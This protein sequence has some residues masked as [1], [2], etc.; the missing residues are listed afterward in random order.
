MRKG[1]KKGGRSG[2][3][4]GRKQHSCTILALGGG[5]GQRGGGAILPSAVYIRHLG[6]VMCS[7]FESTI[8]VFNRASDVLT[9]AIA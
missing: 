7:L 4:V 6:G 3:H 5:R 9:V 8:R 1:E 2:S